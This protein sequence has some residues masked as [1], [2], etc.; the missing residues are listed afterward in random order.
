MKK[1]YFLTIMITLLSLGAFSQITAP[2]LESFTGGSTSTPP[3]GWTESWTTGDGWSFDAG[4]G[5]ALE[6]VLDHTGTGSETEFAHIDHSGT[7]LDAILESDTID[8]SSV[9][10]P[11]LTF[12]YNSNLGTQT[13]DPLNFLYVEAYDGTN[14]I[15]LEKI[16]QDNAGIWSE[17]KYN[18]CQYIFNTDKVLVRFRGSDGGQN[19]GSA[20][21]MDQA[22]DDI[23]VDTL[24]ETCSSAG[25]LTVSAITSSSV[26]AGWSA[27]GCSDSAYSVEYGLS[28]FTLGTGTILNST[29]DNIAITGL[30]ASTPYDFYVTTICPSGDSASAV[31]PYSFRTACISGL[32]G[33]YTIDSTSPTAGTNFQSFEEFFA[34]ALN[35]G[36]DAAT[37]V[38][39]VAGSGPYVVSAIV[40]NIPGS[41]STNTLT[42]NGNANTINNGGGGYFLAL[43]GVKHLT[44]ND[45]MFVNETPNTQKF[46][47]MMKGGCDS[48]TISNNT[49]D[50]GTGYTSSASCGICA[51]N[52][53][54]SASSNGDNAENITID[55]NTIIG[56]YYAISLRGTSTSVKSSGHRVTNNTLQDFYT[57]GIY[58]YYGDNI[59]IKNNDLS[60]PTRTTL[61][62]FYGIYS[63]YTVNDSI[64][65]NKIHDGGTGTYT[66]YPITHGQATNTAAA[67][68]V[69]ANNAIYNNNG[70]GTQYGIYLNST[71]A[72]V[73]VHHNTVQLNANGGSGTIR[74]IYASST[75]NNIDV[76]NNL[77]SIEGTGTGAKACYYSSSSATFSG[78]NNLL[79]MGASG[80]TL[81]ATAY[82]SGYQT[83]I[84]DW[85]TATSTTGNSGDYPAI[86]PGTYTPLSGAIN[87]LGTPLTYL[88][89]D[90]DGMARN[91]ATPDFGAVEFVGLPGDMSISNAYL[92]EKDACY[93]TT[94]TAYATVKNEFGTVIDF[95]SNNLLVNWSVTGP[96][97]S[98]GTT[99]LTS[100]T[101]APGSDT[102]F[103]VTTIDM[104]VPGQY[105]V[106]ANIGTNTVN[107]STTNDTLTDHSGFD[108]KAIIA[109]D[110]I[111]DTVILTLGD[112]VKLSSQSPFF[113]GGAFYITE[114]CQF[115]GAGTGTPSAGRPSW[116][117]ADDYIE[118]TGVPNSDLA[119]YTFEQWTSSSLQS[120]YTFPTGTVM[121]PN[122][123]AIIATSQLNSQTNDPTNFIYLGNGAFTGTNGSSTA[124]G[125]VLKDASG[126]VVDAVGY[127]GYNTFPAAS[128]VTISDWAVGFSHSSGTWGIRLT[129]ADVNSATNWI[130]T[131]STDPQDPNTVNA[132]VV[133]PVPSTISGLQWT[134]I[135]NSVALDTTPQIYAK[136][137]TTNGLYQYEAALIT[138]CGTFKDT[139]DV[140]VLIQTYDTVQY[141]VCDSFTTPLGMVKHTTTGF[142]TDT[143]KGT[144][145]AYDSI[146]HVYDVTVNYTKSESFTFT[147]CGDYLSPSGKTW[148]TSGTYLDTIMTVGGCD[149]LMTFNLTITSEI[150]LPT[151]ATAC[152]S[153][154]W[155]GMTLTTSNVYRDTT[156]NGSCDSIFELTLT[157]N[158]KS[159]ETITTTVCDSLVSPSG[160]VW[161]TTGTYM[162]TIPNAIGCDSIMTF[163]LT[164]NY[165][166]YATIA[167]TACDSTMSPSGKTWTTSGTYLDTIANALG[168][169]SAMTFNVTIN[170]SNS[171]TD[172]VALCQGQTYRVGANVYST[173]GTYTDLFATSHG[174]DSTVITN[175]TYF[176]PSTATVNYN[177]CIGDSIAIL[178]NWY[179]AATT[180]MDTVVGGSSNGCDSVTT[181]II[182]TRTVSPALNLGTDVVSCLDGGVTIFASSAY[183][184]YNWSS[185]GTTN[186][187]SVS[188][189]MAGV[190]TTNHVLTVT[191]ASTGCTAT[192]DINITF[193]SCVGVN[194][195]D[196]DLNVNL[197]P[198]PAT[199]FVT[200]EIFDKY[201]TG[202]LK[203]EILN[204]LGQV[205]SSTNVENTSEKVIM[206]VNNF[207]K[208]LYL[209]RISSDK[210]YMTKKLMISK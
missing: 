139:S 46:G 119:G 84:T 98:T 152:D 123:T 17:H 39:V 101:L 64:L 4:V 13:L 97:A 8:V 37:V 164:V 99:T 53:L 59:V 180:F 41:S 96:V 6:N 76:T 103:Y 128:G 108:K 194:E 51:T 34:T 115:A 112:S 35:C 19:A 143:I 122:G 68:A 167:R 79:Y 209:V 21:Y 179:Y 11:E 100:G 80:S 81:D 117:L 197:Y 57:Y 207:S 140:L 170:Y 113:P 157:V 137:W 127:Y 7:D 147:Y 86:V 145:I 150:T 94:D 92:L 178:G 199:D 70:S 203:L 12:Y 151:S 45:F 162:D 31:G 67:H 198:N 88:P 191:Q 134:D 44:I 56:S 102:T 72:Y 153:Y 208:G 120:S 23:S 18:L 163:N 195:I 87:D 52:S 172:N 33:N 74:G 133:V 121:S 60:R 95:S 126:N 93:G 155:R 154:T 165:I 75:P 78:S 183:D 177:F 9:P 3:T 141:A 118:I 202:N 14:W 20:F 106:S 176:A 65:S 189:S 55:S 131:S 66:N 114:V 24:T 168:C 89:L 10:K 125:K 91:A 206:D 181:H 129:G 204:S 42:F 205:V 47:I 77:V 83:T 109:V 27:G 73:D 107:G 166:T 16:Q 116:L 159:F 130:I 50:M 186:V 171:R 149:S 173:A 190:G 82:Y 58:N 71:Q 124:S 48:I 61:S 22:I 210:L 182:T 26:L 15:T 30:A 188:G 49:I 29:V 201:N 36:L 158:Y 62:T 174:C 156:N 175:L 32:S 1:N 105:S 38:D 25:A 54:T 144:S 161:N 28:G 5:Y 142:Y 193:N 196:A 69:I 90:I 110:P 146:I 185:G 43:D 85:N 111:S 136:G 169:D 40:P 135:T 187:L 192:D 184:T 2:F 104:S 200:I 63:Y 132:N 160:K 138:P 148:T